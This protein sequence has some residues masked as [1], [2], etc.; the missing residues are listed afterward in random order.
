[1]FLPTGVPVRAKIQVTFQEFTNGDYEA[2]EVKRETADFT[3]TYTVGHGETLSGIAGRL[4]GDPA[5]WRPL[6]VANDL[7]DPINL[8]PGLTLV[9][10]RLPFQDPETGEV[11]A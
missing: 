11:L 2:K 5:Q 8:A 1:M 9:V 6:A 4:Y 10:P 7:D 3:K